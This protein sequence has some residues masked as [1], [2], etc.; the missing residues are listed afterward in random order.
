MSINKIINLI[1]KI[2]NKNILIKRIFK[3]SINY[4]LARFL[5]V[6]V[7]NTIGSYFLYIL[8]LLL[9]D[10]LSSFLISTIVFIIISSYLNTKFVFKINTNKLTLFTFF[11]LL[12][13][14]MII[15]AMIIRYSIET[16]LIPEILAPIINIF[17]LTPLKYL[18]SMVVKKVLK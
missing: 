3:K 18:V 12:L 13:F 16:L 14:Q 1:N 10:Y 17:L 9:F 7:F 6:G 8:L 11:C 15:G 5:I 4:Q 2:I